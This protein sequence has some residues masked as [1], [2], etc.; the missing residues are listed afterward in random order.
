MS[1]IWQQETTNKKTLTKQIS[2][3]FKCNFDSTEYILSQKS[4]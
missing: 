1:I 4:N 2:F 3:D